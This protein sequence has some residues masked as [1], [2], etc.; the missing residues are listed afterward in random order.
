MIYISPFVSCV[1]SA[2]APES[3]S[4]T[5][6][7]SSIGMVSPSVQSQSDGERPAKKRLLQPHMLVTRTTPEENEC[8]LYCWPR[9]EPSVSRA[10]SVCL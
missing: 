8:V 5:L 10:A 6:S 3:S 4:S 9:G 7:S 2:P 1:R